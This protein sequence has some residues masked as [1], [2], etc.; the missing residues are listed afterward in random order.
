MHFHIYLYKR[1][2]IKE[3]RNTEWFRRKHPVIREE[4]AQLPADVALNESSTFRM[5]NYLEKFCHPDS[6]SQQQQ[7]QLQQQHKTDNADIDPNSTMSQAMASTSTATQPS[8]QQQPIHLQQPTKTPQP[9]T[10]TTTT[11]D[12]NN[13]NTTTKFNQA[14][15]VKRNHCILM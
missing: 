14:T 5:L 9:P 1:F 4:L 11:L 15:K 8:Q 7:Q 12:N 13:N 3:I 6:I 2:G 10:T